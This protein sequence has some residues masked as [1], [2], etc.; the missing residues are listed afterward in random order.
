MPQVMVGVSKRL[1]VHLGAT[2]SDM[3]TLKFRYESFNV[4]AKYRFLSHDDIHTHFRMA[5]FAE[6][7]RTKA[8]FHYDEI[9]LMG[10]KSG[11]GAGIIATQLWNKLAL[12]EQ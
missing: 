8:P 3:H 2:S 10:D 4:Y 12:S 6:G 1:M 7:S 11:V 5:A 9:T